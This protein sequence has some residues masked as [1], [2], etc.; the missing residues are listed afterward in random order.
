MSEKPH[1]IASA[2]FPLGLLMIAMISILS[3]AS[4]AKSLFPAVGAQGTT[5]LRLVF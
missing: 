3:G 1:T 2:L 5:T 4:L